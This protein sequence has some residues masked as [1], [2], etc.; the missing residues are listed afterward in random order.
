MIALGLNHTPQK[1]RIIDYELPL[2]CNSVK[3]SQVRKNNEISVVR[4][5]IVYIGLSPVLRCVSLA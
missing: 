2:T 1:Q 5:Y 4:L 3:E